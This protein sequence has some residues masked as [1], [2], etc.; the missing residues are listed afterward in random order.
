MNHWSGGAVE[1]W[2]GTLLGL[3]PKGLQVVRSHRK[4]NTFVPVFG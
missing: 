2:S 3:A 4:G 1:R